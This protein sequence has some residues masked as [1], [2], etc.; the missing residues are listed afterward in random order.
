[1]KISTERSSF[2]RSRT[3][4][5][6]LVSVGLFLL[7]VMGLIVRR[8]Y[9]IAIAVHNESGETLRQICVRVESIGD[10]GKRYT[11]PDLVS[12]GRA[13]IYV[14]PVTESHVNVE[15]TDARGKLHVETMVGYAESGYCGTAKLTV[16]VGDKVDT[17]SKL[18]CQK[19][20]L[21]FIS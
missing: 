13:H 20:W 8:Q 14:S 19:S 7:Y 6:V 2:F 11:L 10:R 4:R 15:F 17:N 18:V 3:I 1:M 5:V 16:L 21:D 9:G 12:G